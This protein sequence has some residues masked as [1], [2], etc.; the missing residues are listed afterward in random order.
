MW[1]YGTY[2]WGYGP[3]GCPP[4][5][6]VQALAVLVV[7]LGSLTDDERQRVMRYLARR[8]ATTTAPA[9]DKEN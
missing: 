4:D 2:T 9:P 6:E 3:A 7:A 1:G 5:R 8:F